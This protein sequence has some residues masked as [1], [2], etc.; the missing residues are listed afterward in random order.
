MKVH[1]EKNAGSSV[2]HLTDGAKDTG[3]KA[4]PESS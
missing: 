3:I 4:A 2:N 1:E